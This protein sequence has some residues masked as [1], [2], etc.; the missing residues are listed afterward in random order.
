MWNSCPARG[1]CIPRQAWSSCENIS[2]AASRVRSTGGGLQT[3]NY[4]GSTRS[5]SLLST[6]SVIV[7][8]WCLSYDVVLAFQSMESSSSCDS[9]CCHR[10]AM[11]TTTTTTEHVAN[12]SKGA[13]A[14]CLWLSGQPKVSRGNILMTNKLLNK[15]LYIV[16]TFFRVDIKFDINHCIDHYQNVR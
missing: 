10:A 13:V 12:E 3:T 4:C 2:D 8:W 7:A 15:L 14:Y 16:V 5:S 9:S 6:P 11:L 1:I